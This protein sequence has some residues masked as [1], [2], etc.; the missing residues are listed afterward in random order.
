M[1]AMM[2]AHPSDVSEGASTIAESTGRI[3]SRC[4]Q[5]TSVALR[6]R[7]LMH[8]NGKIGRQ[9]NH[10]RGL[11]SQLAVENQDDR[12]KL[13]APAKRLG[14]SSRVWE[15]MHREWV[16]KIKPRLPGY[17]PLIELFGTNIANQLEEHVGMTEDLAETLALAAS[18]AFAELVRPE[19]DT[20]HVA[21]AR[22]PETCRP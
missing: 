12:R 17:I 4:Q 16:S 11:I 6:C 2:V 5:A 22:N 3:V 21:W 20:E 14:E 8:G 15:E 9:L 10:L 7:I 19:L 13:I 18:E 1:S